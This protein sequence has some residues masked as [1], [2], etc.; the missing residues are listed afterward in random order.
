MEK[1]ETTARTGATIDDFPQ[2]TDVDTDAKAT[3][4]R[5]T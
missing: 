1:A 4:Q 5:R 3:Q 2:E